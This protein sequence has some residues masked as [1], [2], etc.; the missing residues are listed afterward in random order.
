MARCRFIQPNTTRLTLSDGDW[1]DVKSELNAGETRRVYTNLV[2]KMKAGEAAELNPEQ[3]GK[4]KI[5]EYVVGWSLVGFDGK[6]MPFTPVA[7][8]SLD[9]ETYAEISNAIDQHE[10]AVE[11]ARTERK[12]G[13]STPTP[14]EATLQSVAS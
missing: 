6:P 13:R 3:V 12:N 8:D 1:L 7:L 5:Q 4:T 2:K 11:K 9:A 14:S 10:E